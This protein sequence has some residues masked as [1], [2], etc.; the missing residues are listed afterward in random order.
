[1]SSTTSENSGTS[2]SSKTSL[3]NFFKYHRVTRMIV[4]ERPKESCQLYVAEGM[5]RNQH[6]SC[7]TLSVP[8]LYR[9]MKE[10]NSDDLEILFVP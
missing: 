1:M 5:G 4:V 7:Q 6:F 8:L 2:A 9:L 10:E 3:N